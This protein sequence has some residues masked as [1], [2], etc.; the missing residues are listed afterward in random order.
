MIVYPT[1]TATLTPCARPRSEPER[2][3]EGAGYRPRMTGGITEYHGPRPGLATASDPPQPRGR[4]GK[5]GLGYPG[6]LEKALIR[7]QSRWI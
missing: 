4:I 3:A 1:V 2:Q 7:A 5:R 6:A